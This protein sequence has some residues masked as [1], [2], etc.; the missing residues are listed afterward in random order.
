MIV[1][2]MAITPSLNAS[3]RPVVILGFQLKE[4]LPEESVIN[5]TSL[6][7]SV[8]SVS[9]WLFFGTNSFHHRDTEDTELHREEP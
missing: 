8:S 1:M 2:M 4:A 7:N 5:L 3:T 9:L 6:C